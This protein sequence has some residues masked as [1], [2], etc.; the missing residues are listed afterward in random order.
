MTNSSNNTLNALNRFGEKIDLGAVFRSEKIHEFLVP[1]KPTLYIILLCCLYCSRKKGAI[2]REKLKLLLRMTCYRAGHGKE[3]GY[4][5]VKVNIK[6]GFMGKRMVRSMLPCTKHLSH[7]L[8]LLFILLSCI[9]ETAERYT[10]LLGTLF[11][12]KK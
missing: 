8:N 7:K 11:N 1:F 5:R 4:W 10:L 12:L 2:T 6:C 3:H 9:W